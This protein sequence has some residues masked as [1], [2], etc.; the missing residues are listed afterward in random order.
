[1]GM[2]E[3]LLFGGRFLLGGDFSPMAEGTTMVRR[4]P[5][6]CVH[7][8]AMKGPHGHGNGRASRTKAEPT[9][10]DPGAGRGRNRR[11]PGIPLND[12]RCRRRALYCPVTGLTLGP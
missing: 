6:K 3:V 4:G 11:V 10:Q 5:T 9:S 7:S 12:C 1:M 8:T 2:S